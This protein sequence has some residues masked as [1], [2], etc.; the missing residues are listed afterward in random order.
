LEAAHLWHPVV[1][2]QHG[3][4]VT[5]QFHFPQRVERL[6]ARLGSDDAV[7]VPVVPAQIACHGTGHSGIVIDGQDR[8]SGWCARVSGIGRHRH[9]ISLRDGFLVR[10]EVP[11][12]WRR[13]R[14]ATD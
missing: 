2:E 13:T 7:V 8:R 10:L 1:G 5:P 11:T 3:D 12:L 6:L 4:R 14:Q 9:A